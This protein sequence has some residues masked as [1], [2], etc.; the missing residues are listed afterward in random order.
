MGSFSAIHWMMVLA[1]VLLLF[2]AGKVPALMG[3][4]AKGTKA[5]KSGMKDDNA[6]TP[7]APQITPAENGVKAGS[8]SLQGMKYGAGAQGIYGGASPVRRILE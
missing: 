7:P 2:G 1:V 5:F 6:A 3:D 8:Y 4:F